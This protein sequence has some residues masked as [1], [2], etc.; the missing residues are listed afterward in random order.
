M[1]TDG[2]V[3]DYSTGQN[4]YDED[5][6]VGRIQATFR[7]SDDFEN[8]ILVN[9]TNNHS[10]GTTFVWT[11]VNPTGYA[12][13]IF[14]GARSPGSTGRPRRASSTP[15]TSS[16][17]WQIR[18]SRD[19]RFRQLFA[20]HAVEHHRYGEIRSERRFQHQEYRRLSGT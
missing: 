5:Y 2:Y 18:R 14:G 8:N 10:H 13:L 16:S 3:H 7:P 12:G 9:Y 11:L 1:K 17:R 19:G 15:S 6:W 20:I 4:F